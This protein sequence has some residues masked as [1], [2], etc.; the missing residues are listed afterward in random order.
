[1]GLGRD[2]RLSAESM[3]AEYARGIADEGADV[4]DIGMV[5]TEQL[6]WTVGAR[7]LD[8]GLM[9]TA[10]HN[11][12]AYTGAKLVKRGAL[13]LSGDSGIR[14]VREIV[15]AGEAGPPADQPGQITTEDVGD[16]FRKDALGFIDPERITPRKVVLD[17]SNGMAGPMVGPLLDSFPIEQ[18]R[19]TGSLT[20]S[21]P[22]TGPTRCSR[23]TA[24]SS[25]TSWARPAPNSALPGTA[26]PT[27][28]SSSTTPAASWTATS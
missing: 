26:T 4:I 16:A 11:P 6:Y 7:E 10:S 2:M 27:A 24:A 15:T 12:P 17:G 19:P 20:A 18:V 9:C 14:E 1:M 22:A 3:A 25:S 13:A 8:G 21:S 23:R 28:A 5:G